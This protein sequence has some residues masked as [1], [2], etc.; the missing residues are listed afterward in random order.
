[1]YSVGRQASFSI[2]NLRF[3]YFVIAVNSSI[4]CFTE[5]Y[6]SCSIDLL[7][8]LASHFS[9]TNKGSINI[10]VV[11]CVDTCLVILISPFA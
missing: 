4:L 5:I 1:M 7:V 6:H 11:L 9:I 8:Y 10:C 2:I 3:I